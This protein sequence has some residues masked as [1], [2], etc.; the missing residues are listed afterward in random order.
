MAGD[1]GQVQERKLNGAVGIRM[2]STKQGEASGDSI[3]NEDSSWCQ[4]R[5][6]S[7]LILINFTFVLWL[8]LHR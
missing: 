3:G 5:Q 8:V 1:R 6:R 2:Y 7:N 4:A